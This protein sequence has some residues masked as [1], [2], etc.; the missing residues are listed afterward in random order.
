MDDAALVNLM[1]GN[2]RRALRQHGDQEEGNCGNYLY[3]DMAQNL[4]VGGKVR[5]RKIVKGA[6]GP[7]QW[8]KARGFRFVLRHGREWLKPL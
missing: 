5:A 4:G 1:L 8:L 2:I 3:G 7:K 6:G